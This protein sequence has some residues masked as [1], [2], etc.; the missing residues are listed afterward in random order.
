MQDL[1]FALFGLV[2]AGASAPAWSISFALFASNFV[3]A[4]LA[5]AI[6]VGAVFDRRWR[7]A[8]FT[9][10]VSV[11]VAWL[12]VGVIRSLM[13]LPRPA[14]YGLGIQWASQGIRPGFPS[15]H[16]VG[17]FAAAFS[18]WSLPRRAPML[19]ALGVAAVVAWSRVYLGLH[20]PFDVLA[21]IILGAFVVVLVERG[22][23]RPLSLVV[24]KALRTRLR[25]R[26]RRAARFSES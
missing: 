4:L 22:L 26:V 7:Y 14:F 20:F 17:C 24:D 15:L 12:V 10:L 9:M 21:A 1:E 13:P 19:V 8:M 6:A 2:N 16:A 18:L 3:P 25:N 23:S 5:L 11:L